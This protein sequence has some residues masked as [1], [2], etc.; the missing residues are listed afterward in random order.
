MPHTRKRMF[1]E[2][3]TRLFRTLKWAGAVPWSW[4]QNKEPTRYE[5]ERAVAALR[6][7]QIQRMRR[8]E[9]EQF[10]SQ[11]IRRRAVE[12]ERGIHPDLLD[13]ERAQA[14]LARWL[15]ERSMGN[16]MPDVAA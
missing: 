11:A 13:E 4:A 8:L 5:L 12:T 7:P 10:A 3:P 6:H 16:P 15:Q 1:A 2:T 14:R 9:R